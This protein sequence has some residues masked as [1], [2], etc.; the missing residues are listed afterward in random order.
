MANGVNVVQRK[1]VLMDFTRFMGEEL[2]ETTKPH[3]END[4]LDFPF[5]TESTVEGYVIGMSEG[6]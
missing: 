2:I 5:T 3:L 1:G 4:F 6:N